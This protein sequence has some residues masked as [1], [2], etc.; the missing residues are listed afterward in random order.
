ME[1]K[2][3]KDG[4]D[5]AERDDNIS[6]SSFTMDDSAVNEDV[7]D[8]NELECRIGKDVIAPQ[9]QLPDPAPCG[10]HHI[11]GAEQTERLEEPMPIHH[12]FHHGR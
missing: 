6:R 8:E 2:S 7:S 5:D 3:H 10:K 1:D 11:T 12:R 9:P 4:P